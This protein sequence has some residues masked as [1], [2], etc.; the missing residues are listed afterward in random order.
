M[1]E[2]GI[3][4]NIS[5]EKIEDNWHKIEAHMQSEQNVTQGNDRRNIVSTLSNYHNLLADMCGN[6]VLKEMFEN[7]MV[8]SSLIVALYQH[9]DV[10]SCQ[11]NEHQQ[12][13][14]ALKVGDQV[15]A[16]KVMLEHLRH[17]ESE[18]VLDDNPSVVT[19][20]VN[21]LKEV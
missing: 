13:I 11:H 16:I 18:L 6:T 2:R 4:E 15:L 9:N 17:I 5:K 8:R 3:L 1:V 19:D 21:A 14:D 10:P 12:I 7:L 20:L